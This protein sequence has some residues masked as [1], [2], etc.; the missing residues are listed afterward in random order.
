MLIAAA[1]RGGARREI[2]NG[3]LARFGESRL[4]VKRGVDLNRFGFIPK[5][6]AFLDM[7]RAEPQTVHYLIDHSGNEKVARRTL[8]LLTIT[9][10]LEVFEG[11]LRPPTG[12]HSVPAHPRRPL[13]SR[14]RPP[15]S[16]TSLRS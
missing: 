1:L 15:S 13:A 5:E 6:R 9:Q 14:S 4:R 16:R 7:L 2:V 3:V 11:S 10:S 8:Y 12:R